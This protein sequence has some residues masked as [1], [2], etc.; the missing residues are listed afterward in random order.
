M[1]FLCVKI[2]VYKSTANRRLGIK[3][4]GFSFLK[5]GALSCSVAVC[6]DDETN[7]AEEKALDTVQR[8]GN[9]PDLCQIINHKDFI[10]TEAG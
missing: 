2:P 6:H 1:I 8:T 3:E 5:S 9:V 4:R 10:S 7:A